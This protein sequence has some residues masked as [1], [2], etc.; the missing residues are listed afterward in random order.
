[1]NRRLCTA[2]VLLFH[3]LPVIVHGGTLEEVLERGHV[4][5]G[6]QERSPG[7]S[8]VNARG[9]REG[10]TIDQC[11]IISAAV[12]GRISTKYIPVTPQTA[13]V[14]LQARHLDIITAGATWTFVRD[15][16]LGLDYTGVFLYNGQGFMVRKESG[17]DAVAGLAG[18][19]ICVAQGTTAEQNL[20]DYFDGHHMNYEALTFS[21]VEAALRAHETDRCDAMTTER[22]SLAG[23]MRVLNHPEDHQILAEMI[24][25][26]PTAAL[27]RQGDDRWRDIAVWSFNV[28][29]AAEE[30]GITQSNVDAMLAGSDSAEV[31]RLLG[32][33]GD[34]GKALGVGNDWAYKIIKLVGNYQD[35]WNRHFTPFG[36]QR[37]MNAL[38]TDG[39]LHSAL[40][41][42]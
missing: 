18:A 14:S 4:R 16:S 7:F 20:A 28:T 8:T 40:P 24:S 35:I 9:E 2:V 36:L 30:L 25:M 41:F 10:I 21:S 6:I 42:R 5:C 37:G 15:V 34:F 12:F 39:G 3:L 29:L 26:E 17:V 32:L 33:E 27:V 19:T 13:F 11:K 31:R 1:M 38:W 22:L 23:H